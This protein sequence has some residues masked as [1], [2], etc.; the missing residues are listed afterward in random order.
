MAPSPQIA[1][2]DDEAKVD[3]IGDRVV[4]T[5]ENEHDRLVLLDHG[6]WVFPLRSLMV[7]SGGLLAAKPDN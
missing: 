4:A 6:V 1:L 5:D 7:R 3:K 2:R